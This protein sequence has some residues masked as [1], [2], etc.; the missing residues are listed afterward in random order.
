MM[1]IVF[2]TSKQ[3]ICDKDYKGVEFIMS[4]HGSYMIILTLLN[5]LK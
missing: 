5:L 1:I 3:I 4:K 2:D